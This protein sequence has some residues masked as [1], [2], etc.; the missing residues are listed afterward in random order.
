V[1]TQWESVDFS[2]QTVIAGDPILGLDE[3]GLS[4]S[5]AVTLT[6]PEHAVPQ[7][8]VPFFIPPTNVVLVTPYNTGDWIG[9]RNKRTHFAIQMDCGTP[10]KGWVP[11]QVRFSSLFLS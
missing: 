1:V 9:L 10:P 7:P 11:R 4:G 2:A 8:L 6:Y 5:I 3:F